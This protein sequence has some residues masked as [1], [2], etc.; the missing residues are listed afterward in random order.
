MEETS[1]RAFIFADAA[2]RDRENHP[3]EL[4]SPD[5]PYS[6]YQAAIVQYRLWKHSGDPIYNQRFNSFKIMLR[7]FDSRWMAARKSILS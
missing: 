4:R 5:L 1:L 3:Y 6:L 2:V 7:N